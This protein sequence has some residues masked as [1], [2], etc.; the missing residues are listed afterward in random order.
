MLKENAKEAKA[1]AGAMLLA[2][3]LVGASALEAHYAVRDLARN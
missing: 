2:C 3:R 1:G